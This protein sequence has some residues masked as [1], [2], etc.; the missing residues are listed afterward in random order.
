MFQSSLF[1]LTERSGVNL[2]GDF[3]TENVTLIEADDATVVPELSVTSPQNRSEGENRVPNGETMDID[4][5]VSTSTLT[6]EAN[7]C[8]MH[9]THILVFVTTCRLDFISKQG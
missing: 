6:V 1:P 9:L 8:S 5:G 4:K 3:N 2:K 7:L